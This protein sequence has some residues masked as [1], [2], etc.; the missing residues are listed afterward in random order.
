MNAS[1]NLEGKFTQYGGGLELLKALLVNFIN[2]IAFFLRFFFF[3]KPAMRNSEA[4]LFL[5]GFLYFERE[6]GMPEMP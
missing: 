4:E 2:L 1:T 6:V 5:A 3:W